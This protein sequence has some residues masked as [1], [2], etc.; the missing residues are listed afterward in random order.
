MFDGVWLPKL[1]PRIGHCT[2]HPPVASSTPDLYEEQQVNKNTPV[3][4]KVASSYENPLQSELDEAY[5]TIGKLDH[6]LGGLEC[7]MAK[8]EEQQREQTMGNAMDEEVEIE[9]GAD[10]V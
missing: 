1:T 8:R 9:G 3:R 7:D 5:A 6:C 10:D 4:S 2:T